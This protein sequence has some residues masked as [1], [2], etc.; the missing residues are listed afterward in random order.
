VGASE[1]FYREAGLIVYCDLPFEY[2]RI[3]KAQ[4]CVR[5]VS[6]RGQK[7]WKFLS[8]LTGTVMK[9]NDKM[10]TQPHLC[11]KDPYGEAWLFVMV[12][13]HLEKEL[14][15]HLDARSGQK[16]KCLVIGMGNK[17]RSDDAIGVVAAAELRKL[18]LPRHVDVIEGGADEF[19]L[20]EH[21]MSARHVLIIDAVLMGKA[22]G[23]VSVFNADEVDMI[24]G[25]AGTNLHGFGL[26]E[27]IALA[28]TLGISSNITI[29][30][31][32]PQSTEPGESLSPVIASKI[33]AV[34]QAV[35]EFEQ[36]I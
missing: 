15:E 25:S 27:T 24:Y 23:T 29:I 35:E 31:I 17:F 7:P 10:L 9:V 1:D 12:P 14:K 5:M 4:A 36:S 20:I 2:D 21:F 6:A 22:P 3:V 16:L 34:I 28:R 18:Q 8:P 26:A 13:S 19:G 11:Q 32:E 30:G 33:P